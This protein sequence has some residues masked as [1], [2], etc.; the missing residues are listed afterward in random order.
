MRIGD[1]DDSRSGAGVGTKFGADTIAYTGVGC[2]S[3]AGLS[4]ISGASAEAGSSCKVHSKTGSGIVP[5]S[6]AATGAGAS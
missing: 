2:S 3:I 4:S 6:K 5:S 1:R